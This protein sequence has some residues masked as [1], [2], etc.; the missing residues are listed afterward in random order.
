MSERIQQEEQ[1]ELMIDIAVVE[2]DGI[3]GGKRVRRGGGSLIIRDAGGF[4]E[5]GD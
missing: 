5:E 2:N 3:V 1:H 4:E